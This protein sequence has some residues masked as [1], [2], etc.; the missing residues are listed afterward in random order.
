MYNWLAGMAGINAFSDG[1]DWDGHL[2]VMWEAYRAAVLPIDRARLRALIAAIEWNR[3]ERVDEMVDD[4]A[5]A[6]GESTDRDDRFIVHMVSSNAAMATGNGGR[7]F[8]EAIAAADL[9][10]QS[11]EVALAA[12]LTAAVAS[13]DPELVRDAA[14]RVARLPRSGALAQA[15]LREAE[16]ALAA[17]EGRGDDALA[18]FGDARRILLNLGVR[19]DAAMVVLKATTLMPDEPSVRAW[20]AEARPL[21]VELR[22]TVILDMLDAALAAGQ[23]SA[24]T[25]STPVSDPL[26]VSTERN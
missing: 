17:A 14:D 2:E 21:M 3:G 13:R 19:W 26:P 4:V 8:R 9:Q 6:I 23:D 18:A 25:S 1:V 12:A 15:Q 16:G 24:A 20:A 7:A 11:P 10:N 5:A 22:A